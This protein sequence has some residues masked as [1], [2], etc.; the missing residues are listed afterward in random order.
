M[1][2]ISISN[3]MTRTLV[4]VLTL[5]LAFTTLPIANVQAA[6]VCQG[7]AAYPP[8]LPDCLDPVVVAKQQADAKAAADASAAASASAKAAAEL[9]EQK[10][11]AE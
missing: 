4:V 2:S 7:P 3:S 8:D 11:I 9:E 6:E 5:S 10:K 1:K